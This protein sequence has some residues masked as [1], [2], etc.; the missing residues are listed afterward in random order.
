MSFFVVAWGADVS[1][2]VPVSMGL[3]RMKGTTMNDVTTTLKPTHLCGM[4]GTVLE[5]TRHSDDQ[6]CKVWLG[7]VD[8]AHPS[9]ASAEV[10]VKG[11]LR[12][13]MSVFIDEGKCQIAFD[14]AKPFIDLGVL[15]L[16]RMVEVAQ[17]LR[18]AVLA[19]VGGAA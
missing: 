17:D 10:F 14:D 11:L 18:R 12:T 3:T 19:E 2:V 16:D 5:A 6:C 9:L 1:Y 4:L 13:G 8:W 7:P 15:T